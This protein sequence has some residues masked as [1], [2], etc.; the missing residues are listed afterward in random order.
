MEK[1]IGK[2]VAWSI[3]RSFLAE[4]NHRFKTCMPCF[5]LLCPIL[6]AQPQEAS[7]PQNLRALFIAE[8]A[9]IFCSEIKS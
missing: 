2:L 7:P 1:R 3:R 8:S 6:A 5:D 4:V 9:S